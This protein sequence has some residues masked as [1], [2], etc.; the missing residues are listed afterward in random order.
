M[1]VVTDGSQFYKITQKLSMANPYPN[2][3]PQV[4]VV[5][6]PACSTVQLHL[7]IEQFV[8]I[9][10]RYCSEGLHTCSMCSMYVLVPACSGGF[11]AGLGPH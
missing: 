4:P 10:C 11:H 6:E 7:V 8:E 5:W 9:T 1:R 2:T 3:N